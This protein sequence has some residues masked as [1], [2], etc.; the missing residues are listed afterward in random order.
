MMTSH[1]NRKMGWRW[2]AT[3]NVVHVD[4]DNGGCGS[5]PLVRDVN[6]M[7]IGPHLM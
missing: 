4:I 5:E 6:E 7:K 1:G 3:G 2:N